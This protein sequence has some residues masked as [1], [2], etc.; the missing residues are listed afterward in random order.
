MVLAV[1][2]VALLA[3]AVLFGVWSG[4]VWL[5]AL[6]A[7]AV[8]GAAALLVGG[9]ASVL[10]AIGRLG[11][12]LRFGRRLVVHRHEPADASRG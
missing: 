11:L 6:E 9:A 5:G 10:I 4:S 3:A 2:L 1:W 8:A 7:V 12:G